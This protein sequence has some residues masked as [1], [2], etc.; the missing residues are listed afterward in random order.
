[1]LYYRCR[2]CGFKE[3]GEQSFPHWK[4]SKTRWPDPVQ[5]FCPRCESTTIESG[6]GTGKKIE[7]NDIYT[8]ENLGL[9]TYVRSKS[10]FNELIKEKGLVEVGNEPL[11]KEH[12]PSK[13][14]AYERPAGF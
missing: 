1:M 11:A 4:T 3:Q 2:S 7:K 6:T 9:G 8:G 5:T 14:K 13:L 10:H 12:K